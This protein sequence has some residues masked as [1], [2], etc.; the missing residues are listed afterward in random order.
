MGLAL[1]FFGAWSHH[2]IRAQ[3]P[4]LLHWLQ[5]DSQASFSLSQ[6]RVEAWALKH[7][8]RFIST[9]GGLV[10]DKGSHF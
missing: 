2:G 3:Q 10:T 5:K 9:E 4:Q 1:G 7:Q 6:K 8:P